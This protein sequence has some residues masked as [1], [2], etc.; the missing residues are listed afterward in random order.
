MA[1]GGRQVGRLLSD[2]H[3]SSA[4]IPEQVT[5]LARR[6]KALSHNP[7]LRPPTRVTRP[8]SPAKSEGTAGR[9][10]IPEASLI[11][12]GCETTVDS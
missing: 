5:L 6:Q 10:T 2:L 7:F 1:A 11:G 4:S 9:L 3:T 12:K 8:P